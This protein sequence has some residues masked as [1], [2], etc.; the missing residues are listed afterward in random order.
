MSGRVLPALQVAGYLLATTVFTHKLAGDELTGTC[1]RPVS[2][3]KS[4]Y[5]MTCTAHTDDE[6]NQILQSLVTL[7]H[8]I[9]RKVSLHHTESCTS[10]ALQRKSL[11][12]ISTAQQT[13][14]QQA[15]DGAHWLVA[16]ASALL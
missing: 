10:R 5:K 14:V 1:V 15:S 7:L 16:H 13:G 11:C 12:H 6:E 9:T 4:L 2:L 3:T 8:A